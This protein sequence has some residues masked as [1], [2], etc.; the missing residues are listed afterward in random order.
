MS[1]KLTVIIPCYNEEKRFQEGIR[2][3]LAY[4]HRQK[5]SWELI[6]V[7]DGSKDNTL[8]LMAQIAEKEK[9]VKVETYKENQGKGHAI[10]IGV[11]K[12]KGEIILFSDLDHSVPISTIESFFKFF[13]KG[14]NVVIGSRRVEGSKFVQRQSRLRES[15]GRGF[16]L[17][18]KTLIDWEIKDATCG[19]KAFK[20]EAAKKLFQKVTI[21]GWAFDAELLF[22]CKKY[23]YEFIQAPV[24]W[25]DVKGSKVSVAKDLLGSFLGLLKVRINDFTKKYK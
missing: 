25:K 11:Q 24:S 1:I 16:T 7:N 6:L 15:L 14:A 22:L 23:G 4:L 2:H 19:F 21:Y 5:F 12:A 3:Y 10:K 18:V 8:K 17:L 9:K 20:K 13:D